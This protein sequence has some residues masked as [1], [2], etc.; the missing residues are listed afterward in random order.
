MCSL[1]FTYKSYISH[2]ILRS[3]F[4]RSKCSCINQYRNPACE[5]LFVGSPSIGFCGSRANQK[6][7]GHNQSRSVF[8]RNRRPKRGTVDDSSHS[9]ETGT[10]ISLARGDQ[11]FVILSSDIRTRKP[12]DEGDASLCASRVEKK[13]LTLEILKHTRKHREICRSQPV[14]YNHFRYHSRISAL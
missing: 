4:N 13:K 14:R 5:L 9:S 8:G 11:P 10:V 6:Y 7:G 12:R 1:F 3:H 2:I